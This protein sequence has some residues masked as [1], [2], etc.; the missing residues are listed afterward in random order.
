[1]GKAG[2]IWGLF[3]MAGMSGY[4]QQVFPEVISTASGNL[5][6][7]SVQVNWTIGE[8]VI[9]GSGSG[10]ASSQLS[11]GF[12]QP[13]YVITALPGQALLPGVKLYPNPIQDQLILQW[14]AVAA[15]SRGTYR[16]L[17]VR[18][19]E[20]AAGPVAQEQVLIPCAQL[21]PAIYMLSLLDNAGQL[22]H[23]YKIVKQ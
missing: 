23:S 12:G 15:S 13:V 3:C 8:T 17:D 6:N 2:L 22:L 18:G 5:S 9:L 10:P 1:M 7:G 21:A 19:A 14:P 4:A 20:V 16:I 11:S